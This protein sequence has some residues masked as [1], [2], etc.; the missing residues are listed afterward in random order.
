MM[1]LAS[2]LLLTGFPDE[3]PKAPDGFKVERLLEVPPEQGSWVAMTFDDRGRLIFSPQEGPL[4]R[5]DPRQT[6][7]KIETIDAPIGDA[8]GLLWAHD[9]LYIN[10]K[11]PKGC[12][13]YRLRDGELRLLRAWPIEMTEHGPHGIALGP[14][15]KLYVVNGNY[16]KPVTDVSPRSPHRNYQEDL[17]LPR[18]WDATGHAVGLLAPGG[19]VLRTDP[20]GREWELY[21]GGLRNSYDLAFNPDGEIF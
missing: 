21:C 18:Q 3:A 5:I 14:D 15:G 9:S 12:G 6:P 7:L 19:V 20:E 16:T 11:G 10:G 1:I 8:Q 13:F 4:R 17:L 2:I